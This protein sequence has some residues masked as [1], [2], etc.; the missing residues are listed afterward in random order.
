[1]RRERKMPVS[2]T[3]KIS[4]LRGLVCLAPA[5]LALPSAAQGGETYTLKAL[6]QMALKSNLAIRAAQSDVDSARGAV[7]SARAYPNPEVEY[8][9]GSA[10]F[11]PGVDGLSGQSE[12]LALSQPIDLPFRRTPRI[13]AAQSGLA[14]R[15]AG[16]RAFQADWIAELRRGYFD[17]LRRTAERAN[18]Q[19]DL[20]LMEAL[21]KGIAL[22]VKVGD[23][24][25]IELIRAESDL[26]NVEKQVQAATLREKQAQIRLRK[27]VGADLPEDFAVQG[28]LEA[29]L[30]V[31][32]LPRLVD[33]ALAQNPE[34]ARAR[35]ASEQAR[36]RLNYE[37]AGRLP[38][39]SLRAVRESDR[40]MRQFRVGVNLSIPLW[41]RRQGPVREAQADVA[42]AV[43]NLDAQAYAIRQDLEIAYR[44]YEVTQAQVAALEN[45][46]VAQTR[47]AVTMA[48]TAYRAGE[49]G[50]IDV[51]DAQ[52][53]FRAA[54]ADLINSRFELASAWVEIQRLAAPADSR[55]DKE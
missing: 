36:H 51:L 35:A 31:E 17:V 14:S 19:E 48:Q 45:G 46:L 55:A 15:E 7:Q 50:L 18:A 20:K 41:D 39:V 42:R 8:L 40:E 10:R 11:R 9:A 33:Q 1:M 37:E 5:L 25:R 38:S 49:R 4:V 3:F 16:Y 32:P 6:E 24:P 21:H 53:V 52:R 26:L 34:L 44:Q 27:L 12:S 13:A 22:K 43:S 54:R 29:T 2:F 30:S 47:S 28:Q 23:A